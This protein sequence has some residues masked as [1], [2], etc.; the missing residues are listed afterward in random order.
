MASEDFLLFVQ[1]VERRLTG[2]FCFFVLE[3]I[4][5]AMQEGGFH[6][7]HLDQLVQK[8]TKMAAQF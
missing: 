8:L 5:K 2:F 7:T 6:Y 1:V 3:Q 4:F